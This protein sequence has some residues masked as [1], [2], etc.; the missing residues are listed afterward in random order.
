MAFLVVFWYLIS[1][2]INNLKLLFGKKYSI[3]KQTKYPGFIKLGVRWAEQDN[4][5]EKCMYIFLA[6]KNF[7]IKSDCL[8]EN[9]NI[10]EEIKL[11]VNDWFWVYTEFLTNHKKSCLFRKKI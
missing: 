2:I 10:N 6:F 9:M 4:I 3:I 11:V 1:L 7:L 8:D 5:Y